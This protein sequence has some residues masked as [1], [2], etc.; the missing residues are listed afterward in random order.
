MSLTHFHQLTF[1]RMSMATSS[2]RN[3]K[4][5]M[6]SNNSINNMPTNGNEQK[7]NRTYLRKPTSATTVLASSTSA[8]G[9]NHH[10]KTPHRMS[11]GSQPILP[12]APADDKIPLQQ[13]HHYNG[14]HHHY[15][16]TIDYSS[17]PRPTLL[18]A[19]APAPLSEELND[20]ARGTHNNEK[21][22]DYSS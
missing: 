19:I 14:H 2:L 10:V 17:S 18:H 7:S 3:I 8:N 16:Q 9:L 6:T 12:A 15:R 22:V 11:I 21:Q 1:S 13:S 4:P 5:R 20:S